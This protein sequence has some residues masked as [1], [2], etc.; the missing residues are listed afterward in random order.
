MSGNSVETLSQISTCPRDDE[1]LFIYTRPDDT[2]SRR[3]VNMIILYTIHAMRVGTHIIPRKRGDGF[4]A[5]MMR[6]KVHYI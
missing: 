5:H 4:G 6:V 3:T 2:Q 1:L